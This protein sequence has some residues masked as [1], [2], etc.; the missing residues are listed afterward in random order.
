[1]EPSSRLPS[2]APRIS[3]ARLVVWGSVLAFL[4]LMGFGLWRTQEGHISRGLAPGFTLTTFDGQAIHSSDLQ[5]KV[6]V[7]NF[8]ASWCTPCGQE[9]PDLQAAFQQYQKSGVVFLG[10][11]YV[12]TEPQ[13]RAYLRQFGIT[14]PNGPDLGTRI[15]QS[16][17][18]GGVPETYF[19][20]RSGHVASVKIGP[21]TLAELQSILDPLVAG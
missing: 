20:D 21:T 3:L 16:F 13:A 11:D 5:G 17:R 6:V 10:I 9:A 15:S 8:W 2:R 4:T 18:I 14:Y 7:V 19:I 12:D 1:M